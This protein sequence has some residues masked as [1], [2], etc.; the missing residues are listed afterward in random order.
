[1]LERKSEQL[2]AS[3]LIGP[4]I[5]VVFQNVHPE[6]KKNFGTCLLNFIAKANGIL[7]MPCPIAFSYRL[8]HAK[9]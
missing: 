7:I 3:R 6:F 2:S 1:M 8:V 5:I 4:L 9:I